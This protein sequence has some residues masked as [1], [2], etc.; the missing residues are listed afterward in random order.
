MLSL[1]GYATV[2]DQL[3]GEC[4]GDYVG[5]H[6]GEIAGEYA[7]PMSKQPGRWDTSM[8]EFGTL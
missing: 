7:D 3:Y 1:G 2:T 5:V 8:H 4:I 6:V